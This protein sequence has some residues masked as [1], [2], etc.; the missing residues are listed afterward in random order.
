MPRCLIFREFWSFLNIE[1]W[2]LSNHCSNFA[3]RSFFE[4]EFPVLVGRN[5]S[6]TNV[7]PVLTK[8][9]DTDCLSRDTR[10]PRSNH[11]WPRLACCHDHGRIVLCHLPQGV[12]GEE[13]EAPFLPRSSPARLSLGAVGPSCLPRN[14]DPSIFC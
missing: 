3:V 11:S 10:H 13:V 4:N 6:L 1:T 12:L 9:G 14:A 7:Q 5:G 2:A 8:L